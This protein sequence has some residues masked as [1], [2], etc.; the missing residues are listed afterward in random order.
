VPVCVHVVERGPDSLD[1]LM[2]DR[3]ATGVTA[4]LLSVRVPAAL[5]V[6]NDVL[7]LCLTYSCVLGY[8]ASETPPY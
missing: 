8:I 7:Y 2:N 3:Y 1:E 5:S 4:Q 6:R